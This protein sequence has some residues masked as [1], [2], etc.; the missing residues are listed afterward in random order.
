MLGQFSC[1]YAH[2]FAW[3][4]K[5]CI[6]SGNLSNYHRIYFISHKTISQC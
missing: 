2:N 6:T 1:I 3:L 5:F 4:T